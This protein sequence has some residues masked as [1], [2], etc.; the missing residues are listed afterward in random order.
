MVARFWRRSRWAASAV[1]RTFPMFSACRHSLLKIG[2]ESGKC[3]AKLQKTCD[4]LSETPDRFQALGSG[5]LIR[6]FTTGSSSRLP[7]TTPLSTQFTHFHT[8]HAIVSV[9][10]HEPDSVHSIPSVWFDMR[11]QNIC[12]TPPISLTNLGSGTSRGGWKL[13]S[14]AWCATLSHPLLQSCRYFAPAND[15]CKNIAAAKDKDYVWN[16]ELH[17]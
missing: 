11:Q 5:C 9:R 8:V 16:R 14:P 13:C 6:Q 1:E 10:I 15:N 17:A 2:S 7:D 4:R 12:P 3:P